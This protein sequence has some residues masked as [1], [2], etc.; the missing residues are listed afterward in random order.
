MRVYMIRHGMTAGNLEHRYVG[1]TDELLLPESREL[2][3]KCAMQ[4]D[5]RYCMGKYS[6][7]QS[8]YVSPLSRCRETAKL[9]Y[10]DAAQICI[11]DLRECDFG[12]FEYKNYK[13]LNG[14]A[15]YQRFIDTGGCA[16]FPGGES[17]DAFI[18]RTAAGFEVVYKLHLS[19]HASSVQC[20]EKDL[21]DIFMVVHGGTIMALLDRYARPKRSYYDWQVKNGQGYSME[22]MQDE[23]GYWFAD[24]NLFDIR[25]FI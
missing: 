22:F 25:D 21:P 10:P 8:V 11:D 19:D 14:N 4:A 2:I 6:I 9:L 18:G 24:I 16:G 5:S 20:R 3:K 15:D 13:E 17:R 12:L 1:S 23:T 7:G